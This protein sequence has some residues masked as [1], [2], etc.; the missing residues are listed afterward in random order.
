MVMM[1]RE[2]P[3]VRRHDAPLVCEQ[4]MGFKV[5]SSGLLHPLLGNPMEMLGRKCSVVCVAQRLRTMS[6]WL[7]VIMMV[8]LPN[9]PATSQGSSKAP[10]LGIRKWME[11]DAQPG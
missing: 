5:M 3:P 10:K 7:L 2:T 6:W 8:I 1:A 11:V 9:S 4:L